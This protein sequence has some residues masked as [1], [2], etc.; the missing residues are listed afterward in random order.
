MSD[1][2]LIAAFT[3]YQILKN[4]SNGGVAY[5]SMLQKLHGD[6]NDL[7]GE[8]MIL[9][10]QEETY[11]EMYLNAKENPT[12]FGLFSKLGLRTTQDWVIAYFFFSYILF[13]IFTMITVIKQSEQK[14]MAGLAVFGITFVIGVF[15]T[16]S[17]AAYA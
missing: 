17:L 5:T 11:N 14:T 2:D 9:D 3:Q 10:S 1:I 4:S 7:K 12:N 15:A 6:V 16:V 13:S 8:L